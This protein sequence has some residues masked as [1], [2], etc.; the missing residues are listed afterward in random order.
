VS[1]IQRGANDLLIRLYRWDAESYGVELQFRR[2]DDE[3]DTATER[4]R[5]VLDHAE[6]R[7]ML[8][9][10]QQYGAELTRRRFAAPRVRQYYTDAW[11]ATEAEDRDLRVRLSIDR[12]AQ[13]L[14]P[15][16][17]QT[18]G[19]LATAPGSVGAF[20]R[21]RDREKD[22]HWVLA[23]LDQPVFIR[24]TPD[25]L[26]ADA[27]REARK[28][29]VVE[30]FR[31][32]RELRSL[33][34]VDDREPTYRPTPRRPLVYHVVGRLDHRES[35]VITEDDDLDYLIFLTRTMTESPPMVPNVVSGT[36]SKNALLFFGFQLDA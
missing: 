7:G 4:G 13:E 34:S 9:R 29:P 20:R 35:L 23:R 32:N 15:L 11:R 10:P 1:E 16:F 12:T 8:S 21:G 24:A 22:P 30:I 27:L 14:H 36:W 3:A 26:L 25:D 2:Q 5:M 31:W 6:L 19:I 17:W 18:L 28:D 33:P